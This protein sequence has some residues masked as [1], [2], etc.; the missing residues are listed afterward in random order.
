MKILLL[1]P[2]QQMRDVLASNR[3]ANFYPLLIKTWQ[4]DENDE[5][6]DFN[7]VARLAEI[8]AFR[9]L[10]IRAV[11]LIPVARLFIDMRVILRG[12]S[13]DWLNRCRI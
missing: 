12:I 8:Y 5:K 13:G 10:G 1:S 4:L 11:D 9:V 2:S 6:N 7:K 3:P